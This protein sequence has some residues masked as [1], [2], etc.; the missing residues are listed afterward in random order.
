MEPFNIINL[1]A[2]HTRQIEYFDG[3]VIEVNGDTPLED[4]AR[5]RRFSSLPGDY[6]GS[7]YFDKPFEGIRRLDTRI[8]AVKPFGESLS[9][10]EYS[11]VLAN[12]GDGLWRSASA[13]ALLVF[14]GQALSYVDGPLVAMGSL[15]RGHYGVKAGLPLSLG[16]PSGAERKRSANIQSFESLFGSPHTFLLLERDVA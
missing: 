10:A 9:M 1:S 12:M 16:Q 7:C 15:C 6:V 14:A 4:L 13:H 2:V 3:C 5:Q 8:L 11:W